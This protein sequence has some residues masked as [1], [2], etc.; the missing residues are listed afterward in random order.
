MGNKQDVISEIDNIC[1]RK[2]IDLGVNK[3]GTVL[4]E[5]LLDGKLGT[6]NGRLCIENDNFTFIDPWGRSVVDY[7]IVPVEN[8][9]RCKSFLVNTARNMI[10]LYCNISEEV[11][12]IPGMIPDHSVLYMEINTS[13]RSS[14]IHVNDSRIEYATNSENNENISLIVDDIYFKRY[15]GRSVPVNFFISDITRQASILMIEQIE[16]L[17]NSQDEVDK[18]YEELCDIYHHEMNVWFKCK[19]IHPCARK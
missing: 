2:A 9:A 12:N 16:Q 13:Y 6:V 4:N 19:N 3:H 17:H 7:F 5:F 15:N 11:Y 10:D 1:E 18:L 14:D 8:M